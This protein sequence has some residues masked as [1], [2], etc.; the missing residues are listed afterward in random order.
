MPSR[1]SLFIDK[2]F[3]AFG[4]WIGR[5]RRT[6][7]KPHLDPA[8]GTQTYEPKEIFYYEVGRGCIEDV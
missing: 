3:P 2:D 7:N 8:Y 5:V 1:L 6:R 4:T